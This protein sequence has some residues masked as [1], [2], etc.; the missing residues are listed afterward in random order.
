MTIK[1]L[2]DPSKNINRSIEKV[3]TYGVSQEARLKSEISEYVVTDSIDQQF[4]NLL[5][6]ME[7]AMDIGGENEVGVWVSGFYGSGKSSFTKYLGLAFDDRITID[8]VPFI[9]HLQDRL[10]R[11]Q[12]KSLLSNVAK[13]F[14][15]AVLMLDLASEQVAGAT[16]EEVSTVLFYKVLQWAGYS[17]NLKVAA[18][19]RRLKKE[20]RYN[21]F[22][23]AFKE[24]AGGEDWNSYRNDE[25]V[26]DS[27]IPEIAHQL[28]P[29]LFKT[30][31]SFT[32]E[33]SEIVVFENDRVR[34]ML[35]IAREASGK[36]YIIFIIDEVG[37]YVGPR[38]NLILN[39]DGLAKNLKNIGDGKVWIV[40]TA[41]Q[42]LTADDAKAALNSPEL[43]KLNDR[44]P[45]QIALQSNDIKEICYTRL[46]GKSSPAEA[47]L[48]GLF[49]QYGQQL[50]QNTKLVDAR[51]YGVD[52]DRKTFI[53][54][55]PFLP[56]HFD[57][58]LH[59]LG[60]LAKSTGG[61]GLRSAI[62]V[63]QD[64]LIDGSEGKPAVAE[65]AV[66]WLATTVTLFDALDKD[67]KRAF[68]SLHASVEKATKIRFSHSEL[69]QNIAKT[70]A[71]L[72]ILGNLPITRQN[73]T[74]LMHASIVGASQAD[75]VAK[76][77]EDLINDSLV[78]FGEQDGNLC[79]FSEKLN[80]IEQ[81]RSQVA[82]RGVELRRI[83]NE[84]LT[85]VYAPLPST[86]LHG[87][88]AVSTG[89]KAQSA[90]NVPA[91]LAGDRNQIQTIVELVD[92]KEI[93]NAR[94]RLTD[95]S[96]QNSSKFNI[97]LA[98]RTTPEMDELTADIHRCREI[99]NRYRSD[100]DQEIR[101]YCNG[102]AD[103][104]EHLSTKLRAQIQRSLIQGSFIFRGQVVAVDTL[105]TELPDAARKHLSEVA[106]Q[107]FD[108]YAEAPVR[109]GTELAEKFLRVGNLSGITSALDPLN[110]VQTQ[111][112]RHSIR[113]DH[114]AMVS[115]RD[116][117]DR[118]GTVDGKR[119]T[120]IFADAPFGWSAD[121]LRYLVAA[122]LLAGEIK[123]KVAGREVTVNGQ[124]AID[125]IKTNNTFKSIGISLRG[126]DRPSNDVLARAAIRLTELTGD[127]VVP[128][129][130]DI[131]KVTTKLFPQLQ[132]Q[133]G[134]LTEKLRGLNLPGVDRLQNL[135]HEINDVLLTDASD[136]SRRLGGEQS[137]LFDS[138]KWAAE[139]KLKLEQGLEQTLR[140]LRQHCTAI[141]NL[142]NVSLLATLKEELAEA[143]S[144]IEER[145]QQADFYR[146]AADFSTSLTTIRARIRDTVI[147]MQDLL[148]T[149][150]KEAEVD[151]KR[152]P[153][154]IKLTQQEQ[155]ELL[156]SL[157]RLIVE[158][159]PDLLGLNAITNKLSELQDEVQGLK[160]SI[161]RLGTKRIKEE[162]EAEIPVPSAVNEPKPAITRSIKAR[163]KITTMD[164]LD[165]LITQLQQLRG[166]L[167]YAHAFA[168]N[169]E[170]QDDQ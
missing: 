52:F 58:L 51:V 69:H 62:K 110:L 145:L 75:V 156:G 81:E 88:Y 5:L 136:A 108:R 67:I 169:L 144:L 148:K 45:I 113:T 77:V 70:V 63:V 54:L 123:L 130:D 53:D 135:T 161:E 19:E 11:Q 131:S 61:I 44:F 122:M 92:P 36:E 25:L 38:P 91:S 114:L 23:D 143:L 21:E 17:R 140:D 1:K 86:Q 125:A 90:G 101:E 48:G 132:H 9:Q 12:T 18:L 121:T 149:R 37:Q 164:D 102:Q 55:Y 49:D 152:V 24:A 83:V 59:L 141:A 93:D 3:I 65:Q 82:L 98:G 34:E 64:I 20:G 155:A 76:A 43:F 100:P 104:A 74:S 22:L 120:D 133:Y 60:A 16:M 158:V 2:F 6:K 29:T 66:G 57:I 154:W 116:Y 31:S 126:G 124:Q 163:T 80:D 26:V 97:Y 142:P 4:E 167:K 127:T 72:Q 128:L 119:L 7:A 42:T 129:E 79:F 111:S 56:A 157:E 95:E 147:A 106:E 168:V 107:V 109:A 103:R 28:Y 137:E 14:P 33:S 160:H 50:R 10:K 115:I 165:A 27:L 139:V 138:L 118:N 150:I 71:V 68:A 166:E 78:P 112:G 134:P 89:L 99:A 170:L 47:E 15:A 146:F 46:L 105:A 73:V 85:S 153:E 30:P 8:G 162:L 159:T 32:T 117:I 87:S 94:T 96:R 41:Q 84:A 35:E 13:R 39:L 151:L 40:G